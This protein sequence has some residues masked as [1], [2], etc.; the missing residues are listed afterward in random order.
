MLMSQTNDEMIA[1]LHPSI[2]PMAWEFL[3][4]TFAESFHLRITHGTRTIAEQNALWEQGRK[5]PGAIVTNARGGQS[6]HNFGMAFDVVDT[7]RG[8]NINWDRLG[9]IARSVGLEHGDRGM[10]DRPHFQYRDG[11]TLK[12]VQD[13]ARPGMPVF[14]QKSQQNNESNQEN[15]EEDDMQKRKRVHER[16]TLHTIMDDDRD[17]SL[18]TFAMKRNEDKAFWIIDPANIM[19]V[20]NLF[21]GEFFRIDRKDLKEDKGVLKLGDFYRNYPEVLLP[22]GTEYKY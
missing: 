15:N 9:E 14:E 4:K 6:F 10:V 22:E 1:G 2:Q 8:Y 13:G 21:S 18:K 20:V 16:Y 19:E 11:L 5:R 12:Q 17:G 7:E 3:R